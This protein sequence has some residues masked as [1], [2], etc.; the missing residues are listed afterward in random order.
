MTDTLFDIAVGN[1]KLGIG[2]SCLLIGE[3][4]GLQLVNRAAHYNSIV[5][6]KS[7]VTGFSTNPLKA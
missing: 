5:P 3:L 1:V 2:H 4:V 6:Y 7:M